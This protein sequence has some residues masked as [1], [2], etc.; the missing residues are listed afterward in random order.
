MLDA[1]RGIVGDKGLI[2]DPAEMEP[3]LVDWRQRRRGSA[4]AVV[5]PTSTAEVSAVVALCAAQGQP[6]FP[7][8]GNTGLCFGAVPESDRP[9]KPGIMLSLRR[10]NRIRDLDRASGI[11]TV[12]A[13]VV[14]G[15][16]HNAAAEAGRQFPLHLG[17]EGSAQIGG[18]ISTNAGGTGVVRYG[19]MRDLVAG[20]EVVL[21]DG[22]VLND[23]AALRKDNTGYMLR[24]LFIGAEGSLG[25]VTGAAL[26]LH[27]QTPNTAHA[28]VAAAD[29]ADAVALL[30][31]LQDRAGSYIQAFELVSAS[32][33]ELVRKHAER[34]R[35]PFAEIPA[36]SVLIELGS[37]DATTALRDILEE[38]L[39]A[40]L[41]KGELLDAVI[42]TSEQQ[43]ADFWHI[44]H[45]VSEAN[46]KEGMSITHDVAVRSSD[47]APFIKAADEAAAKLFPEAY[48]EVVCHLGDGN[49]HYILMFTHAFWA[50]LPDAEAF[51]LE[52]ER[53]IHDVAARFGGTFSAEHGIGRK[54]TEEL[55]RLADPLR[56]ELMAKV[57]TLFDPQNLMNPGVLLTPKQ[58]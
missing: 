50:A 2:T 4:L 22:R 47:V 9:D 30:A 57:K 31:A 16:L 20:L 8:G 36:W 10:M 12:D 45:S 7:V 49:V 1:L 3:Y 5:Q 6:I 28:W 26:R 33:F 42:A 23:L 14:L 40:A 51:A 58:S 11:A 15:D 24:H 54:L 41:E 34:A 21:A 53:A 48:S 32:Q 35:F 27:P 37:E 29:P 13:G 55:E 25:I 18:L 56:Y 17:S 38:V 46:K 19:P 43:A 44:R 52:V 39:G